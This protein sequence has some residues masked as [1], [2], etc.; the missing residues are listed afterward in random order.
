MA[1]I[2]VVPAKDRRVLHKGDHGND[3]KAFGRLVARSLKKNT[4]YAPVNAQNGVF[5]DGLLKDTLRLQLAYGLKRT[6]TADLA[7]WTAVDP[8]MHSYERLLLRLPQKPPASNGQ[9]LAH[10]MDVMLALG[11]N[12][13]TQTRPAAVAYVYPWKSGD[14]CS[15]SFLLARAI[16]LGQKY[17]GYGN[18][19]TIWSTY[20]PIA[21]ENVAVGDAALYG[22]GGTTT[23][24]QCVTDVSNKTNPV[25]VGFGSA[26]G[27][28]YYVHTRGD[29]MGYRR[30]A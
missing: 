10:Q 5:G 12:R 8:Q 6:G 17:D 26:P 16:V 2:P 19:G 9:K 14:D 15:G 1:L 24:V 18:T 28:R 30:T 13:Y 22:R 3:V 21:P 27:N 29:F 11:M 23:H 7:T 4:F 25:S 20:T